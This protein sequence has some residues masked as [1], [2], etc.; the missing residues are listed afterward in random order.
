[1]FVFD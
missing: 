1:L